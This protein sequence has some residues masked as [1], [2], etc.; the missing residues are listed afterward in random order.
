MHWVPQP[1]ERG[2][3]VGAKV[4]LVPASP[5]EVEELSDVVLCLLILLRR[6]V[7]PGE[8]PPP[9]KEDAP[10]HHVP[11]G[12]VPLRRV[13]VAFDIPKPRQQ[14]PSGLVDP[15]VGAP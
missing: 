12:L 14:H 6:H 5:A 3:A 11:Q 1:I 7:H 9:N 8:L 15:G 2:L 13:A 10:K 4:P